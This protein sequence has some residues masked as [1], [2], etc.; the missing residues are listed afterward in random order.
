MIWGDQDNNVTRPIVDDVK[1]A[2]GNGCQVKILS[3][4]GHQP[5]WERPEWFNSTVIT[6]LND[7]L[8]LSAS[9]Q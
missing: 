1:T 6:F 4:C 9:V 5:N 2:I 8:G 3:G 7:S